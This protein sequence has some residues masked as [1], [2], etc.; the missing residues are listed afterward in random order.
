MLH[1]HVSTPWLRAILPL[2]RR[3]TVV[4]TEHGHLLR[5][6]YLREGPRLWIERAGAHRTDIYIAPSRAIAEAVQRHYRY[7]QER[8]VVIPHGIGSAIAGLP[9]ATRDALRAELSIDADDRVILFVGRLDDAKGILDLWE[10]FAGIAGS[11]GKLI[12]L[13][14]GAGALAERFSRLV[15]R[16]GLANRVR[17]LGF[18]ADVGRLLAA[19][20]LFVLPARHEAFG[21]VLLE[22]MSARVPVVATRTG[23]IPE[24]VVDGETGILVEP[25]DTAS[26]ARALLDLADDPGKRQALGRAGYERWAQ[27]FT[28]DRF[29]DETLKAY[30]TS[31]GRPC[32]TVSA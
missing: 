14:A 29:V 4:A 2:A 7:P 22:A 23:G 18:R 17:T 11:H 15:T 27:S 21:I 10:A 20:D 8:I 32:S 1:D 19:A 31:G 6:T 12:L 25:C 16:S 24:I 26:L 30:R 5:P 13:V 28:L 3:R 9:S